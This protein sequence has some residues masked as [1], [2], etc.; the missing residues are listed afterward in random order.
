MP[1][2]KLV[3]V[4]SKIV[5]GNKALASKLETSERNV[6]RWKTGNVIPREKNI[7]LLES[8]VEK[9]DRKKNYE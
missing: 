6:Y 7:R 5:G 1:I 4:A 3:D 2:K 8:I 9:Y